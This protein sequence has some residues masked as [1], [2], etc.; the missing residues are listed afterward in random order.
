MSV[1][2]ILA[3]ALATAAAALAA[4]SLGV[5]GTVVGAV[6]MSVVASISTAVFI[7]PIQ[8]S[9]DV[10][11]ETLP[12]SPDRSRSAKITVAAASR[13]VDSTVADTRIPDATVPDATNAGRAARPSSV[14]DQQ[15]DVRP[16][17]VDRRV[18]G[19]LRWGLVAVSSLAILVIG[20]G[21]LTGFELV[22][23]RS[24]ASL[25][26]SSSQDGPTITHLVDVTR[27]ATTNGD[28]DPVGPHSPPT[29]EDPPRE[30]SGSTP[31]APASPTSGAPSETP[32]AETRPTVEPTEPSVPA[33]PQPSE[34]EPTEPSVPAEPQPS[35]PQPTEPQPTEPQPS[36]PL[37]TDSAP[38]D[39]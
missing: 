39:P 9:T 14:V 12:I 6:V 13:F 32:P 15:R 27:S 4:S 29:V 37:P 24:A 11:R 25:T 21:V 2:Q 26:G 22:L 17:R 10:I 19:G 33:E 36:E 34:P 23:G 7:Q 3:G 5:A 28:A 38:L 8:R 1:P 16:A 35:E 30:E 20:L 31:G 18:G